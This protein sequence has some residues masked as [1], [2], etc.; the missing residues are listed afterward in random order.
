MATRQNTPFSNVGAG[1]LAVCDVDTGMRIMALTIAGTGAALD[2]TT[3]IERVVVKLNKTI[4]WDLTAAQIE[5]IN[6]EKGVAASA[7]E[8][9]L[10]FCDPSA[11]NAGSVVAGAIDTAKGVSSFQ[12]LVYIAAGAPAAITLDMYRQE[13]AP[14]FNEDGSLA[15][16]GMVRNFSL[17]DIVVAAAG[18]VSHRPLHG[19]DYPEFVQRMHI[20]HPAGNVTIVKVKHSDRTEFEEI[21]LNIATRILSEWGEAMQALLYTVDFVLRGDGIEALYKGN[22]R[23]LLI[24]IT[25][26]GAGDVA[27]IE[28]KISALPSL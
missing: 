6:A 15:G 17:H 16:L 11:I 27:F 5:L 1:N 22:I 24:E 4:I 7:T 3:H 10:F 23:N 8:L 2:M 13:I 12:V 28:E 14:K 18:K 9:T 21:P 25:T 19:P 26:D 20:H